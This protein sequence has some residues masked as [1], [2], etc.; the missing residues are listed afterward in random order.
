MIEADTVRLLRECSSGLVMAT[1]AIDR[2]LRYVRHATMRQYLMKSKHRHLNFQQ[3]IQ[4]MLR[5]CGD[6]GKNPH[7]LVQKMARCKIQTMMFVSP[8]DSMAARMITRGCHTGIASLSRYLNQYAAASEDA[9]E[10]TKELIAEE[11]DLS[12]KIRQFL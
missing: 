8:T 2:V 10:L 5:E 9:K 12:V 4:G 6:D 11:E 3:E 7:P 1:E